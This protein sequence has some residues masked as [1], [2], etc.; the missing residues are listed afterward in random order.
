MQH[1]CTIEMQVDCYTIIIFTFM[2]VL[3]I[4]KRKLIIVIV[5]QFYSIS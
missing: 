1:K 4:D 2:I 5:I 3:S